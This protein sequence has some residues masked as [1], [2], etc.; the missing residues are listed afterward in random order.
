MRCWGPGAGADAT[1]STR[2]C[3]GCLLLSL[4]NVQPV[5]IGGAISR[6]RRRGRCRGGACS[7]ILP[8]T[9]L[10]LQ[11]WQVLVEARPTP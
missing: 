3:F 4:L 2:A 8:G 6:P 10:L 7:E 9:V 5:A 11:G 1:V